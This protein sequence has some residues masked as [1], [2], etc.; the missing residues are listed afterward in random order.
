MLT[1]REPD[2]LHVDLNALPGEFRFFV[3]KC[4]RRDPDERFADA[5][6]ALESF[7]MLMGSDS[8]L[9]PPLE[10]AEKLITEWEESDGERARRR[11]VQRLDEHLVRNAADQ[12]LYVKVVPRLPSELADTY[13]EEMAGAFAALLRTYDG[14]ISGNLPFAYCDVVARFYVRVF[15]ATD[16][17]ELQRLTLSRLIDMGASHNRWRVGELTGALLSEIRDVSQ[18]M[19]V[20]EVID[21]NPFHAAWFWDPWMKNRKLMRPM[22]EAF[23]R[24]VN[25]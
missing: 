24:A 10:A 14:Y 22:A 17:V 1:G 5:G 25:S 6:E 16:S 12:E 15:R 23:A 4:T 19:V 2:V 18:A 9:D 20:A 7:R 11:V 21:A 3:D 8:L 13:M